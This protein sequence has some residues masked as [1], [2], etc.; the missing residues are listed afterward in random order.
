[1]MTPQMTFHGTL[2]RPWQPGRPGKAGAYVPTFDDALDFDSYRL[3]TQPTV[4]QAHVSYP[5]HYALLTALITALRQL[6][7]IDEILVNSRMPSV[8]RLPE[9][10]FGINLFFVNDVMAEAQRV[11]AEGLSVVAVDERFLRHSI[12]RADNSLTILWLNPAEGAAAAWAAVV[13]LLPG[14]GIEADRCEVAA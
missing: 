7:G 9:A 4:T 8:V 10:V 1:M 3:M 6:P 11:A 5:Q 14:F 12:E 2:T 13:A